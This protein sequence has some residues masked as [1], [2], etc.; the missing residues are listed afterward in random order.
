MLYPLHRYFAK[1]LGDRQ[2][3]AATLL[4]L[5]IVLMIGGPLI[6]LGNSFVEQISN[7]QSAYQNNALTHIKPDP[8]V[9][10]WPLIG[11]RLYSVWNQAFSNLPDFIQNHQ[12]QIK[13]ITGRLLSVAQNTIGSVF[14]LMGALVI[15]GIMMAWGESGS[16]AVL[17]ISNRIAGPAK[18]PKLQHL[19]VAVIRSV[20]SGVFGVAFIQAILFGI[21]FVLAGVPAAG[22]LA[23]IVM[24]IAI[25]QLPTAFV[26]LPVIIYIWST[27]DA[28]VTVNAVFTLFFIVAGLADN[29]LKPLL[30]GHGVDVPMPII[31]IGAL[32]GMVASGLIGLF[33]GA[34]LLAIAHQ[35]FWN[36][37]D[38]AQE[39]TAA[40]TV[41]GE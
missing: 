11:D 13:T 36:W 39:Q 40:A 22:V 6:L 25:I 26:A 19:S 23:L 10:Q 24:F 20:A 4:I 1:R 41:P 34:I 29:V 31:L 17:R 15:A 35:I 2:G 3:L 28:S 16:H 7:W 38:E 8:E 37:V 33:L 5:A 30:L 21:G 9:A 32:G 27:G 12:E 18:G 14:M